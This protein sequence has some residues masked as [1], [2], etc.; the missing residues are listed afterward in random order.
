M[1]SGSAPEDRG[2]RLHR[3]RLECDRAQ[4]TRVR[5]ERPGILGPWP[6]RAPSRERRRSLPPKTVDGEPAESM[7][8]ARSPWSD[9]LERRGVARSMSPWPPCVRSYANVRSSHSP[10]WPMHSAGR[11]GYRCGVSTDRHR[12]RVR[13]SWRWHP[14][15]PSRRL[16]RTVPGVRLRLRAPIALLTATDLASTAAGRTEEL[17]VEPS[18]AA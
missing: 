11:H 10:A 3:T 1:T 7:S 6:H 18:P 5:E 15:P 8:C 16:A 9:C 2:W 12:S 13:P 4:P 17:T 14:A